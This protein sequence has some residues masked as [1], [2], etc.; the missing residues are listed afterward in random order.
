M[1]SELI[2]SIINIILIT[3]VVYGLIF[4]A[5]VF[6]SKKRKG[7]PLLYLNL[8]VLAITLNNLQ[9]WLITEGHV[10]T[11]IYIKF[12]RIPWYF[13]C[14]PMF[15]V[16]MV[17]YLKIQKEL[18]TFLWTTVILFCST[19]VIRLVLIHFTRINGFDEEAIKSLILS[20]NINEEQISFLYTVIL[21]VYPIRMFLKNRKLLEFALNYD[22]L[23]WVKDF[24]L[25]AGIIIVVWAIAAIKSIGKGVFSQQDIYLPLRLSTT[26]LIYWIGFKGLLRYRIM[27]DRI[28]LRESIA[29]ERLNIGKSKMLDLKKP[30]IDISKNKSEKQRIM[31]DQ[32]ND[33]VTTHQNY[34]NPEISLESLAEE[35]N[36]S[37]GHLSHLINT[38][39]NYHFSDYINMLRVEQ[40]KKFI[41]DPEF[42]NYTIVAIGLESGFNSKSTFYA[43]FKKFTDESPSQYKNRM[44][45]SGT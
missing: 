7:K 25:I 14:M 38:Y 27:E 12:L 34:L 18:N 31:Y 8:L 4:N 30:N 15:Y 19:I 44:V 29:K 22:D 5:I 20:Y 42:I 3:G 33:H 17:Y 16:F 36:L 24:F 35:L 37:S 43:A 32:I 21:F 41:L 2:N 1:Q 28:V 13:L 10:S 9:A 45:H 11:N 6:F 39:G 40:A 26:I 23:K